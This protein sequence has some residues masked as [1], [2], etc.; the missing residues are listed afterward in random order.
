[1]TKNLSL[2]LSLILCDL[3]L[4]ESGYIKIAKDNLPLAEKTGVKL[5]IKLDPNHSTLYD[6]EFHIAPNLKNSPITAEVLVWEFDDRKRPLQVSRIRVALNQLQDGGKYG[7]LW[8]SKELMARSSL[9]VSGVSGHNFIDS[10][11]ELMFDL[12]TFIQADQK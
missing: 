7:E 2:I 1:M 12:K 8:L 4:A 10:Q 6:V 5:T 3:S 11:N 9:S